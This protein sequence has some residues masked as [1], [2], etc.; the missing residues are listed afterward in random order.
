MPEFL[1]K[2]ESHLLLLI[3]STGEVMPA[4]MLPSIAKSNGARVIEINPMNSSFT[5]SITDLFLQGPA[6]E[7]C[8][9]MDSYLF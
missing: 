2:A 6:G 4:G 9:L 3:G 8:H 1:L 7:V 5:D